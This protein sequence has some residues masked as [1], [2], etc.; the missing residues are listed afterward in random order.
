MNAAEQSDSCSTRAKEI[1]AFAAEF[2]ADGPAKKTVRR[3]CNKCGQPFYLSEKTVSQLPET[4]AVNVCE[5][6]LGQIKEAG[7]RLLDGGK[8]ATE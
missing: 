6:C 4:S 5:Q 3:T 2:L 1:A 7:R 8:P